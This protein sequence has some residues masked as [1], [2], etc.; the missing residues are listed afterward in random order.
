MAER[1]CV[2]VNPAAGRGRGAK[3]IPHIRER[4]AEVGVTDIFVT[5]QKGDE[6]ALAEQAIARGFTTIVVVGGDGTTT[7]VANAIL[8]SGADTRLGV[9]PAGTGNDFA[10]T[11]GTSKLDIASVARTSVETSNVR[12]DA[13]RVEDRYFINCLG[14]GFDVAVL[15]GI[16]RTPWLRGNAVYFYTA[17]TQLLGYRG[18]ELS[19]RADGN[20]HA[21]RRHLLL[22]IANTEYFGGM[23]RIAPGASAVDG[24]LDAVAILDVPGIRRIPML[25]RAVGGTHATRRECTM[26]RASSFELSFPYP[27]SYDSDGELHRAE[28]A[29]LTVSSCAAALR[30]MTAPGLTLR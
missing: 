13:G 29:T 5:R 21:R 17:L 2:V 3:M 6:S 22:V 4:F 30:A 9:L 14:F 11:L 26:T 19:F 28:S 25:A 8:K 27:P 1:V 23:F 16:E 10:K 7:H 20:E 24:R 12:V 15:E 18:L